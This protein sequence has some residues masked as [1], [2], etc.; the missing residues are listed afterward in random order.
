MIPGMT[1]DEWFDVYRQ[2]FPD[3]S[4]EQYDADW[5]EFQAFKREHE[6]KKKIQ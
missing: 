1:K 6:R 5:E 4:Q 3:A 2:F